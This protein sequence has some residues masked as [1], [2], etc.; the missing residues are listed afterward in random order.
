[1]DHGYFKERLSAYLDK[2]L[3]ADEQF[4]MEQHVRECPECR[5]MLEEYEKLDAFV[6]EKAGL[7]DRDYWEES[8]QRIEQRLGFSS[9]AQRETEITDIRSNWRGLGWKIVGVAASVAVLVFIGVHQSDILKQTPPAREEVPMRSVVSESVKGAENEAAPELAAP[10]PESLQLAAR[11][12]VR[13]PGAGVET[14]AVV[15]KP[16]GQEPKPIAVAPTQ[17]VVSRSERHVEGQG[18]SES[19]P[20]ETSGNKADQQIAAPPGP[21]AQNL[22]EK[23]PS[24]KE[25]EAIAKPAAE[26]PSVRMDTAEGKSATTIEQLLKQTAGALSDESGRALIRGGR[27]GEAAHMADST[28][29]PELD[30]CRAVRDSLRYL[31]QPE[32]LGKA[33]RLLSSSYGPSDTAAQR[34]A[35]SVR[36]TQQQRLVEAAY[37]IAAHTPD[38]GE[39][40]E[41]VEILRR[42]ES[43]GP[44]DLG[45]TA[46]SYRRE[47]EN[48]FQ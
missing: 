24:G 15:P 35:D 5:A 1:M 8:A 26:Q 42:F 33:K 21:V 39:W 44:V 30:R 12:A 47:V 32:A 19:I 48:R 23:A 27:S 34:R 4:L 7:D 25:A 14:T 18:V 6:R 29:G 36:A 31:M 45:R 46:G 41:A 2:G 38:R 10:F 43:S 16:A 17:D 28:G 9:A 13:K 37:Y 11:G 20:S 3:P 22:A 40:R